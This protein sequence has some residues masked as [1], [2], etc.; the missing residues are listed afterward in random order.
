[1]KSQHMELTSDGLLQWSN[2]AGCVVPQSVESP[3]IGVET[4]AV[5]AACA[6][7]EQVTKEGQSFSKQG[8]SN[9]HF[10]L[11]SS[12]GKSCLTNGQQN[13]QPV[14]VTASCIDNDLHQLWDDKDGLLKNIGMD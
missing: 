7:P 13:G 6:A 3:A 2:G 10:Q 5:F 9:G 12:D 4:H 8:S 14:L 1:M 11:V